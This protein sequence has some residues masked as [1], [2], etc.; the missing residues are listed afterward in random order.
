MRHRRISNEVGKSFLYPNERNMYL[1]YV[2][3]DGDFKSQMPSPFSENEPVSTV[4]PSDESLSSSFMNSPSVPE[5][6]YPERPVYS[7]STAA[8]VEQEEDSQVAQPDFSSER[9]NNHVGNEQLDTPLTP[10]DVSPTNMPMEETT[11]LENENTVPSGVEENATDLSEDDEKDTNTEGNDWAADDDET[12]MPEPLPTPVAIISSNGEGSNPSIEEEFAEAFRRVGPSNRRK[13]VRQGKSLGRKRIRMRVRKNRNSTENPTESETLMQTIDNS[14]TETTTTEAP[15]TTS[16]KPRRYRS[17]TASPNE[18]DSSLI[19][20]TVSTSVSV[21]KNGPK[22]LIISDIHSG[23]TGINPVT[24][25]P[26]MEKPTSGAFTEKISTY[27]I[28]P[29]T[30]ISTTEPPKTNTSS[31]EDSKTGESI[32]HIKSNPWVRANILMTE[33]PST[34]TISSSGLT[35]SM[36]TNSDQET[37][38]AGGHEISESSL[39]Q[40][41]MQDRNYIVVDHH[42]DES[43]NDLDYDN[44]GNNYV[45]P[46]SSN[47]NQDSEPQEQHQEYQENYEG[48]ATKPNVETHD[49]SQF[50]SQRNVYPQP[51]FSNFA[52]SPGFMSQERNQFTSGSHYDRTKDPFFNGNSFFKQNSPYQSSTDLNSAN[53]PTGYDS[54]ADNNPNTHVQEPLPIFDQNGFR[55]GQPAVNYYGSPSSQP[56]AGQEEYQSNPNVGPSKEIYE[57]GK[58]PNYSPEGFKGSPMDPA[59]GETEVNAYPHT[60]GPSSAILNTGFG[61]NPN[62][63]VEQNSPTDLHGNVYTNSPPLGQTNYPG[64]QINSP[65]VDAEQNAPAVSHQVITNNLNSQDTPVSNVVENSFNS[66]FVRQNYLQNGNY[67]NPNVG[68]KLVATVENVPLHQDVSN[69]I[70]NSHNNN[71][72]AQRFPV[73][74]AT[75]P[76]E[77]A[78]TPQYSQSPG[79]SNR[80]PTRNLGFLRNHIPYNGPPPGHRFQNSPPR[81][82][83]M[84]PHGM[85]GPPRL[86]YSNGPPNQNFF[87]GGGPLGRPPPDFRGPS[88]YANGPFSGPQN[89]PPP[90]PPEAQAAPESHPNGHFPPHSHSMFE[91]PDYEPANPPLPPGHPLENQI[92]TY[93]EHSNNNVVPDIEQT[94]QQQEFKNPEPE[95]QNNIEAP[96]D[97]KQPTPRPIYK[98]MPDH[99]ESFHEGKPEQGPGPGYDIMSAYYDKPPPTVGYFDNSEIGEFG[100]P[101][102]H[103]DV[104]DNSLNNVPYQYTSS[105]GGGLDGGLYFHHSGSDAEQT[106]NDGEKHNNKRPKD[107]DKPEGHSELTEASDKNKSRVYSDTPYVLMFPQLVPEEAMLPSPPKMLTKEIQV[108]QASSLST[109]TFTPEGKPAPLGPGL[110]TVAVHP[111]HQMYQVLAKAHYDKTMQKYMESKKKPPSAI[112]TPYGVLVPMG[113]STSASTTREIYANARNHALENHPSSK[114]QNEKNLINLLLASNTPLGQYSLTKGASFKNGKF[115]KHFDFK[116]NVD[117]ALDLLAEKLAIKVGAAKHILSTPAK[118]GVHAFKKH[119]GSYSEHVPVFADPKKTSSKKGETDAS[120]GDLTLE[121]LLAQSSDVKNKVALKNGTTAVDPELKSKLKAILKERLREILEESDAGRSMESTMSTSRAG[122]MMPMQSSIVKTT[123]PAPSNQYAKWVSYFS[124]S[125]SKSSLT[126]NQNGGLIGTIKRLFSFGGG[127]NY[128]KDDGTYSSR[129]GKG[130][131]IGNMSH[132]FET[133]S[134]GKLNLLRSIGRTGPIGVHQKSK[135][136]QRELSSKATTAA[137]SSNSTW[138]PEKKTKK[139]LEKWLDIILKSSDGSVKS[140][141]SQKQKGSSKGSLSLLSSSPSLLSSIS[142][143]KD[144][145]NV[146]QEK[147]LQQKDSSASPSSISAIKVLSPNK[148]KLTSSL[149]SHGEHIAKRFGE[150]SSSNTNSIS[151]VNKFFYSSWRPMISAF[152]SA[153]TSYPSSKSAIIVKPKALVA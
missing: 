15:T 51:Q 21:V 145:A 139:Q 24:Q 104:K 117:P 35:Y 113:P 45:T 144:A 75:S 54:S 18:I 151:N 68:G 42:H 27:F 8:S 44:R 62:L 14:E 9:I 20:Q 152:R 128:E 142:F 59:A 112:Y 31:G 111:R 121:T 65:P 122:R 136:Q 52:E 126:S 32:I 140:L 30:R 34:T 72:D 39:Q 130:F 87:H 83:P 110:K 135:Q 70:G 40:P 120:S 118:I 92:E 80:P 102:A 69:D 98:P 5:F 64:Q 114:K 56:V 125:N 115:S 89:M 95:V 7:G 99:G 106:H 4:F 13:R 12:E 16:Q 41:S 33:T 50:E 146:R 94:P 82:M 108:V 3:D 28:T 84:S 150:P 127:E 153:F 60:S 6:V 47:Q 74:I 90:P 79:V 53:A 85:H 131:F 26:Q 132:P 148:S 46:L 119:H 141:D 116:A 36:P 29:P 78:R 22:P 1:F 93:S 55:S 63:H 147:V 149:S 66:H 105:D 86:M 107:T 103:G 81:F 43:T 134:N 58:N 88:P 38:T 100:K 143:M 37:S 71:D 129:Q 123:V 91:K 49:D 138:K 137:S 11:V 76:G 57:Y 96:S 77:Q 73:F 19:P 17:T 133:Y 67:P 2:S 48:E 10:E 23:S 101:P 61:Y 25:E 109:M 97:D 124:N